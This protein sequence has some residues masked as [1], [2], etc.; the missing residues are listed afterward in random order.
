[1]Q[2]DF[3]NTI[4]KDGSKYIVAI[5]NINTQKIIHIVCVYIDYSCS[6]FTFLNKL[7]I[8]I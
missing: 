4:S 6:I 8:I 3:F 5:F 7:Q 2:L 1:M